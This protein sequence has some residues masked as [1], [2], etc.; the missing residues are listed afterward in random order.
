[1][2]IKCFQLGFKT[3]KSKQYTTVLPSIKQNE[4]GLHNRKWEWEYGSRKLKRYYLFIFLGVEVVVRPYICSDLFL[5]FWVIIVG[6]KYIL[7]CS[8]NYTELFN[9]WLRY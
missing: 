1:M 2:T 5:I 4:F 6:F 3:S 9:S 8:L 7:Q